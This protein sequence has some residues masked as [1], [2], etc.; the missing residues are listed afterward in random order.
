MKFLTF[1]VF[2]FKT[3]YI[4]FKVSLNCFNYFRISGTFYVVSERKISIDVYLPSAFPAI[5]VTRYIYLALFS[6]RLS[7]T[8][9]LTRLHRKRK[10]TFV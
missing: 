2:I 4:T 10:Q 7:K 6:S 9:Q 1:G 3:E 5:N 8:Q